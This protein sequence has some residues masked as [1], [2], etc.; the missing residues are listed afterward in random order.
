MFTESESLLISGS[1]IL[2]GLESFKLVPSISFGSMMSSKEV[3]AFKWMLFVLFLSEV[4]F[5]FNESNLADSSS[6][7]VL[8]ITL[9][10]CFTNSK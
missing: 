5:R 10:L 8:K 7:F 9:F 4:L 6:T 2:R 1:V 3:E